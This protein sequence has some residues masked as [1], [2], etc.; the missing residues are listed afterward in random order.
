M[1]DFNAH[2]SDAA[3]M[4]PDAD[5]ILE[6]LGL[7]LDE[8]VSSSHVPVRRNTMDTSAV[9]DMGRLLLSHC[10]LD[11]GL[12]ALN[13]RTHGDCSGS[14][15]QAQYVIDY[16][17]ADAPTYSCIQNFEVLTK[18]DES[19]HMPLECVLKV[20]GTTEGISHSQGT[21]SQGETQILIPRWDPSKREEFVRELESPGPF[22]EISAIREG[23]R[24][25]SLD[26]KVASE[27]L[28]TVIYA[29]AVKVFGVIGKPSPR[30]PSGR[31]KNRWYKHCKEGHQKLRHALKRGDSHAAVQYRKEFKR[32]KRKWKRV[33]DKKAQEKMLD[34]LKNNPRKFWTAFQVGAYT[35]VTS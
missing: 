5:H 26:L 12:F 35:L 1:G 21:H 20:Q 3:D 34:Y 29:A 31:L 6:D 23:I 22:Q 4:D 18:Q 8:V 11:S 17:L 10:C 25:G 14:C 27:R 7:G 2:I 32:Q 9:D 15:T 19:D 13:G 30:L 28:Y 16:G 24:D 33:Y